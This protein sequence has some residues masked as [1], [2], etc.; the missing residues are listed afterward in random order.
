M[1]WLA[2]TRAALPYIPEARRRAKANAKPLKARHI[3]EDPE[4]CAKGHPAEWFYVKSYSGYGTG[5]NR[6]CRACRR[7][8]ERKRRAQ[9]REHQAAG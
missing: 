4:H 3:P 2:F 9:L 1:D 5:V 6:V 8:Y 7:E